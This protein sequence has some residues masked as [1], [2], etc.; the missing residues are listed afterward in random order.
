MEVF[1]VILLV[2]GLAALAL[3]SRH[4]REAKQMQIRKIMHDERMV[5]M[6]KGIPF[7]ELDHDG[8]A[9]ELTSLSEGSRMP[10]SEMKKNLIWIR[11]AALCFGLLFLFGGIGVTAGFP[12]VG[13]AE[14]RGMW[15]LG[16]IPAL[17]GIGLL[18]FHGLC[19]GYDKKL[20]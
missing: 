11:L 8:M 9:R 3:W 15:P 18:L 16:L 19:R 1:A 5:A 17:I 4:L 6:E 10:E 14:A 2:L 12:L 13:D 7:Q 20:N